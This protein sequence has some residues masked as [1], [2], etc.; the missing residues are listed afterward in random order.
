[1]TELSTITG[2]HL[3]LCTTTFVTPLNSA[4]ST[5]MRPGTQNV[6]HYSSHFVTSMNM[7]FHEQRTSLEPI[8]LD[9]CAAAD[10]TAISADYLQ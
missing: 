5:D 3:P 6:R 1:M 9:L 7:P 2:E 4:T 8:G 10:V